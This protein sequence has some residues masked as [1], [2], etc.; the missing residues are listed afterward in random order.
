MAIENSKIAIEN[1]Y[2]TIL[3]SEEK[4][5]NANE[6]LA[7]I[8]GLPNIHRIDAFD[9]SNLFGTYSVSGMVVFINGLPAKKE[10]R[11]YKIEQDKNDDYAMMKEE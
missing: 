7:N 3:R 1:E 8:L 2:G 10:Y 9:N 4:S 11:K 5:V 6:K